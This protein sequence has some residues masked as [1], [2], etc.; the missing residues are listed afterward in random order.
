MET[1]RKSTLERY[2]DFEATIGIEVHLQ[3][4]TESKIFCS[5]SNRFGDQPNS[6][7]C[8]ICCGHPGVLPV[9][10]RKVV[11]YAIM[12]GLATNCTINKSS[13]FA[14]KHYM[15]PDLPKNY[16][17]T[18]SDRPICLDGHISI[19]LTDGTKKNVRLVRIHMEEDAGKNLHTNQ[20][21]SLVNLNRAGTPLL[22][23]VSHPDMSNSDEARAY[24]TTL[25]SIAQYLGISDANM[26]EGSFRA[27]INISVRRKGESKLGT[28]VELK[29][30]NSFKFIVQAI[31]FEIERQINMVLAGE[32]IRQETRLWDS[33]KQQSFFMRSKEEAQDYRYF[34]E[35]DLPVLHIDD[36][37]I[38]RI[39]KQLP[40]LAPQK[41]AR[42][43]KEYGLSAYEATILTE[44]QERA[45][46]FEQ[47]VKHCKQPKITCNV[48][49]RDVL[50]YLKE[51]KISLAQSK[52]TPELFAQLINALANKVINSSTAQEVFLELANNG[53]SPEK[54]IEDN[55]LKQMGS[56]DEIEAVVKQILENNP[57]S[58]ADYKAGKTRLFGFFVGQAMKATQGK[59]D[60][61]LIN[62]ILLKLLS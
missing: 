23:I 8:Q 38:E 13:D 37:W 47:T 59:A 61:T 50:S 29:N 14:R 49:L 40:E 16:Q 10:N 21:Y 25:H 54:F 44:E 58:V 9:L 41:H 33:K 5:C 35:P 15:Y 27:D 28:K 22:E 12:A 4:K 20:G 57:Q 56:S 31:E 51:H 60:P 55:N 19:N 1:S 52:I 7:I 48:L 45:N 24:L 42:F 3:L 26:D 36:E 43:I 46:F 6:N 11:D 18:Q 2:P 34:T 39:R 62:D 53:T 30:I 17:I 32:R